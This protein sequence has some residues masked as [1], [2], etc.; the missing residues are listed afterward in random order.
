MH[1]PALTSA[2][3][4]GSDDDDKTVPTELARVVELLTDE[5]VAAAAVV[6]TMG[7]GD[8]CPILPGRHYLDW[9]LADPMGADVETVRAIRNDIEARV[10]LLLIELLPT[11]A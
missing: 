6:I 2:Y 9:T 5:V 4:D 3:R 7:C 11:T 8:A 1:H 10:Q